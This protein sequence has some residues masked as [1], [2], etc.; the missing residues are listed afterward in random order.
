MPAPTPTSAACAPFFTKSMT[1]LARRVRA[2]VPGRAYRPSHGPRP[3]HPRPRRR[4]ARLVGRAATPTG[5]RDRAFW[6]VVNPARAAE[7]G[8][9]Q[10][11]DIGT[12]LPSAANTHQVA[13]AIAPAARVVY[14]D[15]DRI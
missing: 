4:H 1:A 12:G 5:R 3:P 15:N 8:I 10:F 7:C 11:L 6:P 14:V 9:R 2:L 13:Q